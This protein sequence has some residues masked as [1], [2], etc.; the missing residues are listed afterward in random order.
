MAPYERT[1]FS[2]STGRPSGG[3]NTKKPARNT[4]AGPKKKTKNKKNK[5]KRKKEKRKRGKEPK[6]EE[7][8]DYNERKFL[9]LTIKNVLHNS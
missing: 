4:P 9:L 1:F 2:S 5:K 7:P 8:T 6:M 3:S